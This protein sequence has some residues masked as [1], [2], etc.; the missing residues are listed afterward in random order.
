VTV[1]SQSYR[2]K[3][4]DIDIK[5]LFSQLLNKSRRLQS[6]KVKETALLAKTD[7]IKDR[8][9]R[10]KCSY[11]HRTGHSEAKCWRKHLKKKSKQTRS[12]SKESKEQEDSSNKELTFI[13]TKESLFLNKE[14]KKS[15]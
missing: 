4:E 14:N 10:P 15:V 5:N 12:K 11:C 1:I 2:S 13:L 8:G 3:T 6:I 7:P 9:S